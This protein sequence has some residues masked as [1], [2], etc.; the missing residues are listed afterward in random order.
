[1]GSARVQ[2]ELE[3]TLP[4]LQLA[5]THGLFSQDTELRD[6]TQKRRQF[7]NALVRRHALVSDYFQYIRYE[8]DLERLRVLRVTSQDMIKMQKEAIAHIVSIF[9]RGVRRL[10]YDLGLWTYYIKWAHRKKMRTVVSRVSARALALFP[11]KVDLWLLVAD[12]E[13]NDYQGASTSRALLQRGLRLNS[14]SHPWSI[15]MQA[16]DRPKKKAKKSQKDQG[17]SS[18]SLQ[19]T[20]TGNN[21]DDRATLILTDAEQD[22]IRIWIQY[23]RMELV[24][25]ERLRRRRVVLGISEDAEIPAEVNATEVSEDMGAGEVPV[26]NEGEVAPPSIKSMKQDVSTLQPSDA[27]LQGAIPKAALRSAISL[28]SPSSLPPRAHFALLLAIA[29]LVRTFPFCEDKAGL[30]SSILRD[31]NDAMEARFPGDGAV[32]LLV[33]TSSVLNRTVHSYL[34]SMS[35]VEMKEE[36]Q[37]GRFLR[38]ASN[39]VHNKAIDRIFKEA[40]AIARDANEEGDSIAL[41]YVLATLEQSINQVKQTA[42]VASDIKTILDTVRERT[43]AMDTPGSNHFAS[44]LRLI[45]FFQEVVES[46]DL[47]DALD[48]YLKACHKRVILDARKVRCDGVELERELCRGRLRDIC[49]VDTVDGARAARIAE[50]MWKTCE[51][52][53]QDELLLQLYTQ[54]LVE[55]LNR[56]ALTQEEG[57]K[58]WLRVQRHGAGKSSARVWKIWVDWV[59]AQKDDKWSKSQLETAL[60]KTIGAAE[61]HEVLLKGYISNTSDASR[62]LQERITFVEK[63]AYPKQSFWRWLI[64]ESKQ[65]NYS[66]EER[67][68]L[69]KDLHTKLIQN[70]NS[71]VE[72]NVAYLRFLVLEIHDSVL[73][74]TVFRDA[75]SRL[76]KDASKKVA[77]EQAWQDICNTLRERQ[78]PSHSER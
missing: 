7:E 10:R 76:S 48:R 38:T 50:K 75:Q 32:M 28:Q 67:I 31:I 71:D 15:Q 56:D 53:P 66:D 26:N 17:E 11:N 20:A 24:F 52:Y 2:Y 78:E 77:L 4:S 39:L 44:Q 18:K 45:R 58:C 1:M 12:H 35:E 34:T 54:S 19:I 41:V 65:W 70:V 5:A 46:R 21:E 40:Q 51:I 29:D 23:I 9:E 62:D 36:L 42:Q 3:R 27:L 59:L 57:L 64:V 33:S 63:K 14:I 16:Q 22:L 49:I 47:G 37:D 43:L 55:I 8:E 25:I 73:G 69:V 30:R 61:A 72:D 74:F 60:S 13:L 6:I 68:S